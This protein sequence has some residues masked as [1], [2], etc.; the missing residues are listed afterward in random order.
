VRILYGIWRLGG[1]GTERQLVYVVEALLGRGW[2]VHVAVVFPGAN[3]ERLRRS[4]CRIHRV[5]ARGRFDPLVALRLARLMR[6]VRPVVTQTWLTQMD[7]L[8]GAAATALGLPWILSERSSAEAYPPSPRHRLRAA[9]GRRASACIANSEA[10]RDYWTRMG[11]PAARIHVVPNVTPLPAIDAAPPRP[12][13]PGDAPL[14]VHVG[15]LSA[16][17][18][19]PLVLE[20]LAALMAR[21]P[22]RALLFGDGPQEAVLRARAAALGI[23]DRVTFA[24]FVP[25]VWSWVKAADVMVSL[26][27]FEGHPNAVLEGMACQT[28][29]VVSDIAA[30]RALLDEDSACFVGRHPAE[31]AGALEAAIAGGRPSERTRRARA[32][33]AALSVD[34]IVPRYE[35]VYRVWNLRT[36]QRG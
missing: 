27:R 4:G 14:I 17:K 32:R 9:V 12:R 11:L 21:R 6:R 15:R 28:P 8:A 31:V 19:V 36:R 13:P 30:H 20:S 1:G 34:N 7:I 25:D 10:G 26:S 22:A 3:D 24:G 23:A 18:D 5:R 35:E 33:V 16:E 2:D 29:L